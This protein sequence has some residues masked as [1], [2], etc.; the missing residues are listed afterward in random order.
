MWIALDN[1]IARRIV[2]PG[3]SVVMWAGEDDDEIWVPKA[4]SLG[5]EVFVSPDLDVLNLLDTLGSDAEFIQFPQGMRGSGKECVA[6]L[7][8]ELKKIGVVKRGSKS[9]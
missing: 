8:G 7:L 2:L 6:W 1:Q 3:H 5:A 9:Q 4:I